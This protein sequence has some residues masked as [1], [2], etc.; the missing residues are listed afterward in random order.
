MTSTKT[1]PHGT[2]GTSENSL[3]FNKKWRTKF[4]TQIFEMMWKCIWMKSLVNLGRTC[5]MKERCTTWKTWFWQFLGFQKMTE[6]LQHSNLWNEVKMHMI[7]VFCASEANLSHERKVYKLAERKW[8]V[9]AKMC[10]GAC[11]NI[12]KWVECH[13]CLDNFAFLKWMC[14]SIPFRK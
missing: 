1:N 4:N 7:E 12:W 3:E 13:L 11:H 14:W 10:T 8:C 5:L 9:I 2:P 6:K